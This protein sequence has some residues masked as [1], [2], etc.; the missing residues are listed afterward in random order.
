MSEGAGLPKSTILVAAAAIFFLGVGTFF[1]LKWTGSR[2]QTQEYRLQM[3]ELRPT[4]E[5]LQ[6]ELT[7]LQNQLQQL[8]GQTSIFV[9]GQLKVCNFSDEPVSI[10]SL[11]VTYLDDAGAFRTFHSEP[12]GKDLW[13]VQ[14][15]Q[16]MVLSYPQGGWDGTVTYYAFWLRAGGNLYPF[17]G[18]WPLDK[19]HCVNWTG[20]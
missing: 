5:G 3:D 17:A 12:Y 2:A 15:G 18:P 7:S 10:S 4:V 6:A 9:R 11:A 8:Q 16:E 1:L 19:D 14:P 13:R 20:A